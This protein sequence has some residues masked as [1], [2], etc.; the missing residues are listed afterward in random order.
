VALFA[1]WMGAYYA[2]STTP[3]FARRIG[4]GYL[5][6]NARVAARLLGWLG[7]PTRA[8]GAVVVSPRFQVQIRRGCDA[9]EPSALLA[10]AILA[11]PARWRLKLPGIVV[12]V[13]VLQALN[14][15]RIISL[16]YTGVHFRSAFETLHVEVWQ[17]LFVL[18]VAA[19]WAG[20]F[21]WSLRYA[22]RAR[23]SD[24]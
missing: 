2:V 9:L 14:L 11:F 20:W 1:L 10:A 15:V 16:Y 19:V 23:R 4:P 12:G 8:E 18:F 13:A 24:A 21:V 6:V 17:P 3:A 5:E 7:E 22:E